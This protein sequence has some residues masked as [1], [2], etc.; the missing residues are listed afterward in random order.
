MNCS[1]YAHKQIT[2]FK[3]S[4]NR[5][6]LI[7]NVLLLHLTAENVVRQ[8]ISSIGDVVVQHVEEVAAHS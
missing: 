3:I 4:I 8:V 7:N 1:Y 6:L 2:V 5:L